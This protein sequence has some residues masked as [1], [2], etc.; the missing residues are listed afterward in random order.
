MNRLRCANITR[1]YPGGVKALSGIT[2]EIE[3]GEIAVV[4]G[5]SGSGKTT[6]LNILGL[7][8]KPTEGRV[9]VDEK[10]ITVLDEKESTRLMN[11]TFGFIFQFFYLIPELTVVENVMLPL[12]IKDKT[13]LKL[14]S[15]YEKAGNLL[16]EF[17]MEGRRDFYPSQLSGGEL[18]RVAICRSLVCEPGIIFADEP[19]G[20]IDKKSSEMFFELV[21]ELNRQKGVTFVIGTHNEKFLELATK[22]ISLNQGELT[23]VKTP[24]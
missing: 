21:R 8:D 12:W 5:P 7:L 10:E 19:T 24:G 15:Y 17:G 13:P 11:K 20:S 22:I 23:E 4:I 18:Q 6:L 2:L 16:E 1:E 9:Y 14:K 3:K